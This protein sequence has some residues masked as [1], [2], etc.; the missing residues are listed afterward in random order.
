MP[1]ILEALPEVSR[2]YPILRRID[3]GGM[4]V[5]YAARDRLTDQVVALKCITR[6]IPTLIFETLIVTHSPT[7]GLRASLANEF[8]LLASLIHPNIVRVLDYG[9]GADGLPFYTMELLDAPQTILQAALGLPLRERGEL[10]LQLLQALKYLHRR[11]VLH[12]DIKPANVLVTHGQVKVL[13]FGLSVQGGQGGLP[14]G[15]LAYLAPEV[16]NDGPASIASDLY[17]VGII[18]Y[19]IL[20]ERYPFSA[21]TLDVLF[22]K[23]LS[24]PPDLSLIDAPEMIRICVATLLAKQP[25]GRYGSTAEA[26]DALAAAF[27]LPLVERDDMRESYLHAARFIGREPERALILNALEQAQDGQGA[28]WMIG[29]ESGVGKSR[30]VGEIATA[31]LLAG[32]AVLRGGASNSGPLLE[33]WREPLR[34]LA[35]LQDM[36]N[37]QASVLS[38]IIPDLAHLL[39]RAITPTRINIPL[40]QFTIAALL[41]R[42]EEPLLIVLDDLQW[43]DESSIQVLRYL[44]AR[45]QTTRVLILATFRTG[46][47][48]R[49]LDALDGIPT[50]TLPRLQSTE[51]IAL[52]SSILGEET[53]A[54]PLTAFLTRESEGNILFI[55][56]ILRNLASRNGG[57]EAISFATLPASVITGGISRLLT[58]RLDSVPTEDRKA[59]ELAA[60]IGRTLDLRLIAHLMPG[61][62]VERWIVDSAERSIIAVKENGYEFSHDKLRETLLAS[63]D[64]ARARELH[65]RVALALEA[66]YPVDAER[67]PALADHWEIAGEAEKAL[68]Y[69]F[70]TATRA[71]ETFINSRARAA[72]DQVLRLLDRLPDTPEYRLQRIDALV[73]RV[74]A[75]LVSDSPQHNLALLGQASQLIGETGDR[76]RLSIADQTR[77]MALHYALGR[78]YYYYTQPQAAIAQFREMEAAAETLGGGDLLAVPTSLIG[79]VRSLQGYFN[80]AQPLLESA[81]PTLKQLGNWSDWLWNLGYIGLGLTT[82]GS[83]DIGLAEAGRA[84]DEAQSHQHFSAIPVALLFMCVS[85]WQAGRYSEALDAGQR[86]I[87]AAQQSGDQMPLH[88]AHGFRAWAAARSGQRNL[89]R[90]EWGLYCDLVQRLGGRLIYADWFKAADAEIALLDGRAE[91]ALRLADEAI[92]FAREV[93]GIFAEGIAQRVKAQA[94][95][96]CSSTDISQM[97]TCLDQSI[98]LF[99]RGEARLEMEQSCKE[100]ADLLDQFK[101]A[102][103]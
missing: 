91:R 37:A 31:A 73:G 102:R 89:A 9:F 92:P 2:R 34:R 68:V 59:L 56:E 26:I 27:D 39:E 98:A 55:I 96:A 71:R 11:G 38:E 16:L 77:L 70:H 18:A 40:V 8:Q 72:F 48:P 22:D 82:R 93:D 51:I 63:L 66:I 35:V 46:E 87:E 13:D 94:L 32:V 74:A 67:A 3:A 57:L 95:R 12:R 101:S 42:S 24:E 44:S 19:Q 86:V 99:A 17:A 62:P 29:G 97:K 79:R 90:V 15:T 50:I 52:S 58:R 103:R 76:T 30:F 53:G 78:T 1:A 41:K 83:I 47:N 20:A 75:S 10:L 81:G 14:G 49:L 69:A 7:A 65:R 54:T 21:A 25:D 33:I 5:V 64:A 4:G 100:L 80:E 28:F 84:L 60:V 23:I 43:A 61:L 45:L 88:L 36:T 6:E 85:A